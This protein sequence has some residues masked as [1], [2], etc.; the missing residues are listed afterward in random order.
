MSG[1]D[2]QADHEELA[3]ASQS[4]E[5]ADVAAEADHEDNFKVTTGAVMVTTSQ[6]R[7]RTWCFGPKEVKAVDD[8][9]FI[10]LAAKKHTSAYMLTYLCQADDKKERVPCSILAKVDVVDAMVDL[11]NQ[12]RLSLLEVQHEPEEGRKAMRYRNK[13]IRK[14]VL[15]L[16]VVGHIGVPDVADVK[17][18]AMRVM[19]TPASGK[20]SGGIWME[21]TPANL[22][23]VCR[24]VAAQFHAGGSTTKSD[25]RK[26]RK[27]P[28][29]G[30]SVPE[31]SAHVDVENDIGSDGFDCDSQIADGRGEVDGDSGNSQAGTGDIEVGTVAVGEIGGIDCSELGSSDDQCM[32]SP[33]QSVST[34]SSAHHTAK[35][36]MTV[37][38]Y[39]CRHTSA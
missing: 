4:D 11:K 19:L 32:S 6:D 26:S 21:L 27:S 37:L 36:A 39:L 13:G 38:D 22:D 12:T 9:M 29:T 10:H 30:E 18:L 7:K 33:E 28:N 23:Y 1:V 17:G 8:I 14:K 25:K 20:G 31:N 2:D 35:K 34:S 24:A 5:L 3:D 15:Q 16:P